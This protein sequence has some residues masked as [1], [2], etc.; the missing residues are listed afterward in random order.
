MDR[1][2]ASNFSIGILSSPALRRGPNSPLI[3][4]LRE[5]EFYLT[6]ICHARIYALGGAYRE[7]IRAGIFHDYGQFLPLAAGHEGGIVDLAAMVVEDP[8]SGSRQTLD[9][10]LYLI[11]PKDP[12][13]T[14]P[15][16][17]ALK[18]ECVVNGIPFLST[19]NSAREWLTL[20]WY[21]T[22]KETKSD[23]FLTNS[24]YERIYTL[25]TEAQI[26]K[27]TL[28]L[29]AHDQK[30]QQ[31]LSFVSDHFD[32][33]NEFAYRIGTGTTATLLNGEWPVRLDEDLEKSAIEPL[34]A[35]HQELRQKLKKA[36][37]LD[38]W[39]KPG[40][41]GPRGGDVAIANQVLHG[42]CHKLIF[43][44]D[45]HVSHQHAVDIQ[46]LERTC[47][48]NG[49]NVLCLHD[50]TSAVEW[51]R[52]LRLC[53]KK[54]A[55]SPITL[56]NAFRLIF[57]IEIVLSDLGLGELNEKD[58]LDAVFRKAAYHVSGLVAAIGRKR[59]AAGQKAHVAL[60]W[61]RAIHEVL[62]KISGIEM[63]LRNFQRPFISEK[64][65]QL[66]LP[67]ISPEF[68]KPGNI[69]AL[70]MVGIMGQSDPR[71]EANSN[72]RFAARILGGESLTHP[73]CVF[74]ERQV[75]ISE[76]ESDYLLGTETR[77]E[78]DLVDIA[79]FT[80]DEIR[81]MFG[82]ESGGVPP[83]LYEQL[84][85]TAVGEVAGLALTTGGAEVVPR[86]YVRM[87]M[88]LEQLKRVAKRGGA[89]L[90]SC[91]QDRRL[92]ATLACMRAG[93]VSV[94]ITDCRF[95]KQLIQRT[96]EDEF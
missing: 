70:P 8:N 53:K 34:K 31:M 96:L 50:L 41:S 67:M 2:K 11:D 58:L 28:A 15:E 38:S 49:V 44:E 19:Y 20:G 89:V 63:E 24:L 29:V 52:R 84:K 81:P 14:Y 55:S 9:E 78:W 47:R 7:V 48:V 3:L 80:C 37:A 59:T 21:S 46:L 22:E 23:S 30:K 45:P 33:L 39:V 90:I 32:I 86:D 6:E 85:S 25:K 56:T 1:I 74:L 66:S 42:K 72:A 60:S 82:E 61:G 40:S 5:F 69:V 12:T 43:F 18:R 87:G 35:I 88:T 57:G 16:S 64:R 93:I 83:K 77:T 71:W 91:N 73:N 94:L 17:M 51:S 26:S 4:L 76:A 54:G 68:Q 95:A 65:M 10:V 27:Q 62:R 13:S 92:S 75:D 36:G 79:A